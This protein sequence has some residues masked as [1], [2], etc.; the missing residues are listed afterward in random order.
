MDRYAMNDKELLVTIQTAGRVKAF[1]ANGD[2]D[3]DYKEFDYLV[4]RLRHLEQICLLNKV[5]FV[6]NHGL[7]SRKYLNASVIDG[8]TLE[9]HNY[10]SKIHYPI[11]RIVILVLAA[12]SMCAGVYSGALWVLNPLGE[13]EPLFTFGVFLSPLFWSISKKL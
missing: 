4:E 10:I 1:Q 5:V 13:H 7:K 2:T 6:K 8:L 12:I 11:I 9:G 3:R